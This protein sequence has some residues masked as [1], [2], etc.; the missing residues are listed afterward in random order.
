MCRNTRVCHLVISAAE[1][2]A[3]AYGPGISEA[4]ACQRH[5]EGDY[6]L[7]TANERLLSAGRHTS[8][9]VLVLL[10]FLNDSIPLMIAV[11]SLW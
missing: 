9:Q 11:M 10:T 3:G 4:A 8:H 1:E 7:P 5:L 2:D 6:A